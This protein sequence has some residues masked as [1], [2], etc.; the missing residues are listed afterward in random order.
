MSI[1][2][3]RVAIDEV[4]LLAIDVGPLLCLGGMADSDVFSA[5]FKD[6]IVD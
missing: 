1:V 4:A 2:L 5:S 3:V 6:A